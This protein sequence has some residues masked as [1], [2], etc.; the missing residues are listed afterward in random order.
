[1]LGCS[2]VSVNIIISGSDEYDRSELILFFVLDTLAVHV[3]YL[4]VSRLI[5]FRPGSI[6]CSLWR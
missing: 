4:D 1:M 3:Q 2:Q 5:G 6:C